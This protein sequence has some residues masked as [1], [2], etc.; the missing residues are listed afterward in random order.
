MRHFIDSG[1]ASSGLD[2]NQPMLD[3][4]AKRCPEALFTLQDMSTFDVSEPLDLITCFYTQSTTTM[5]SKS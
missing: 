1:Y 5:A 2:I 3:I 4:A